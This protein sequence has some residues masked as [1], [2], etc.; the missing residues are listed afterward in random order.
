MG[1]APEQIMKYLVTLKRKQTT[2][3]VQNA[4]QMR[5]EVNSVGEEHAKVAALGQN[6]N[7][8]YF[9]VESVRRA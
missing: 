3:A 4:R 8:R 1:I 6:D 2:N 9:T 5:V 7:W